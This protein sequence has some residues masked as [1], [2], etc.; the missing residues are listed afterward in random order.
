M[1]GRS[2]IDLLVR[3][4]I[5]A[6]IGLLAVVAVSPAAAESYDGL[7]DDCGSAA[8][9][10]WDIDDRV[11]VVGADFPATRYTDD[12]ACVLGTASEL[13]YDSLSGFTQE[14]TAHTRPGVPAH[15]VSEVATDPKRSVLRHIY[16]S[17]SVSVAPTS[18]LDDVGQLALP[19]GRFTNAEFAPGK[20]AP[21]Y[22]DHAGEYGAIG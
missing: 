9:V 15:H 7:G 20:L 13:T 12:R 2:A 21:H 17:S 3:A 6:A 19:S 11:F 10:R 18:A 22:A 1:L 5:S 14:Y 4:V 8:G 16:D